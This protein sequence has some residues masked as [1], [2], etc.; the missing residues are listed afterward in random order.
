MESDSLNTPQIYVT[1]T[2]TSARPVILRSH[3]Y[4][5]VASSSLPV[6]SVPPVK[7]VPR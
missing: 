5:R 2:V 1:E 6:A 3:S 4:N 7:T